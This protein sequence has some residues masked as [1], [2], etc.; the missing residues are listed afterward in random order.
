MYYADKLYIAL[1]L[2]P[3]DERLESPL[4]T[5]LTYDYLSCFDCAMIDEVL[6]IENNLNDILFW[7]KHKSNYGVV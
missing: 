2:Y 7:S 6:C 5:Y 4:K 1:S 3:Y